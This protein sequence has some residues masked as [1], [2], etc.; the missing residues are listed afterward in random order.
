[1]RRPVGTR[2]IRREYRVVRAICS[3]DT[4][5]NEVDARLKLKVLATVEYMP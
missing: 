2:V 3:P 4:H 1:M 5:S